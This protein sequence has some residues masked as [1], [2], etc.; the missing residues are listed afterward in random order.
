MNRRS[1]LH[2]PTRAGWI[3]LAFLASAAAE[4]RAFTI[5]GTVRNPLAQPVAG[6]DILLNDDNGNP[7][8]I[9]PT[10]TGP[11]GTYSITGLPNG[12]YEVIFEPPTLARLV[13]TSVPNIDVNNNDPVVDVTLQ[14]GFLLSGFV[15]DSLGA[16]LAD[17]DLQVE[18]QATNDPIITPGDNTDITG[19]YDVVVPAADLTVRWRTVLP[20][21][22]PYIDV[23]MDLTITGD[24]TIDVTMILGVFVSGTVRKTGGV[25]VANANLDFVVSA[26]GVKLDTPGDV[27][28]VTGFYRVHVPRQH[29]DIRVK[30]DPLQRLAAV[31][32]TG[33]AVSADMVKNF[34]LQPGF[35]ISGLVQRSTGG[36]VASA[37]VDVTVAGTGAK[38]FTP[39]DVTDLAGAYLV[40][41][42]AGT[43]DVV[44][45]PPVST[46]LV[47][48]RVAGVAV[49]TDVLVSPTLFP[50]VLLTGTVRKTDGT[51]VAGANIDA[52]RTATGI[53][54]P[55]VG[56]FTDAAGN[57]ATVVAPDTYD[58]EFEPPFAL[59]L[60]SQR[61]PATGISSATNVQVTLAS[62]FKVTGRATDFVGA[63]LK[64]VNLDVVNPSNGTTL[65]TPGDM[66]DIDGWYRIVV[67]AG[68]YRF[69][70]TPDPTI[71]V[72]PPQVVEP[73]V[74]NV[75]NK[76]VNVRFPAL[77]TTD[78]QE[79]S[80][81]APRPAT[82]QPVWP[83]PFN[84]SAWIEFDLAAP[85]AVDL[86]VYDARGRLVRRLASGWFE[87]GRHRR[88]WDGTDASGTR[89]ASG[90][91]LCRL[92]AAGTSQA[93]TM[94]LAR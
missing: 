31:E 11:A 92:G 80:R 38:V 19:Y 88:H 44:F 56:D 39:N 14:A 49:A 71:I 24:T 45:E 90:V 41:V 36:G 23:T 66:T 91:Y 64:N 67:P 37:D 78:V 76:T 51:P 54:V 48:V 40:F 7:I 34:T 15:R 18:Y 9:P 72:A 86:D 68:T 20:T 16:P 60:V 5:S 58:L 8:G 26:T 57:F 84:P 69:V 83:N 21:A 70:F 62:G 75:N 6:V 61:L 3:A 85:G 30:P 74:V 42:P 63:L 12:R 28:D 65:F 55:L 93:R 33:V 1:T 27:T 73:V 29:Y 10:V 52:K 53:E 35:A 82:L 17:I 22:P 13:A 2:L 25:S 94:I 50:G 32:E 81:P 46:L 87:A 79:G 77:I 4:A 43:Y 89:V 47:P 59:G